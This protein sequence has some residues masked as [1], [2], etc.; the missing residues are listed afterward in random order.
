[1]GAGEAETAA[2]LA[3]PPPAVDLDRDYEALLGA[4][5][6]R[7]WRQRWPAGSTWYLIYTSG[8]TGQPKGVIY[9]FRM[10]LAN[11]IN[12]GGAIRLVSTDT[13]L[14]FLPVF[15]TAGINLHALPTLIVG[16]RVIVM[17]GF[18]ADR[19]VALLEARRLDTL[20]AVP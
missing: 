10:A 8:T 5:P 7:R 13:N 16:G 19:L 1:H 12:I 15:H 11:H 6:V 18:D 14:A 3:A 20:F 2:A 9:T 17:D 4:A